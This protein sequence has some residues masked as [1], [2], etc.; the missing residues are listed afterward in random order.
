MNQQL[1]DDNLLLNSIDPAW[2]KTHGFNY[3]NETFAW[4]LNYNKNQFISYVDRTDTLSIINWDDYKLYT[5]NNSTK[6]EFY[7]ALKLCKLYEQFNN[8]NERFR[9]TT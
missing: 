8:Q 1:N 9:N 5:S 7:T 4:R 2:W 3:N 6:S